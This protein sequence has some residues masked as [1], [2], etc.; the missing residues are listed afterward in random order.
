[1][2]VALQTRGA[3]ARPK[4]PS[5]ENGAP[6]SKPPGGRIVTQVQPDGTRLS[7]AQSC[8]A[9]EPSAHS[10]VR[11]RT[12]PFRRWAK[13]LKTSSGVRMAPRA[14]DCAPQL[15]CLAKLTQ[16]WTRDQA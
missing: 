9:G 4:A 6:R 7:K 16:L 1:M 8:R 2:G 13:S 11:A 5:S 3:T 10:V 15:P 12:M 14:S